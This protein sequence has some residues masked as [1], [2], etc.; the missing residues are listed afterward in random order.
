MLLLASR[1]TVYA[2][3][4]SAPTA[5]A[6]TRRRGNSTSGTTITTTTRAAASGPTPTP[7]PPG[8][9]SSASSLG[10]LRSALRDKKGASGSNLGILSLTNWLKTALEITREPELRRIVDI[11]T[12]K[13]SLFGSKRGSSRQPANPYARM[14]TVDEVQGV[15]DCLKAFGFDG[16]ETRQLVVAFPQVLCYSAEERLEDVLEYFVHVV[17]IS[18]EEVKQMLLARPTILGLPRSQLEQMIGF[19]VENGTSEVGTELDQRALVR[20]DSLTHSHSALV[21]SF[22]RQEDI[23]AIIAKSL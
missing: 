6:T 12:N 9:K 10:N 17:G 14:V 2:G 20:P 15:V 19:L 11:V 23:V 7:T 3:R 8:K 13:N 4:A 5:A 1:C 16:A 18:R 22:V 21:R